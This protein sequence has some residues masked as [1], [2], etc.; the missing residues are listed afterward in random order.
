MVARI[1]WTPSI[2]DPTWIGWVTVVAYGI[3]VLLCVRAGMRARQL[4][5]KG[6][7]DS[8]EVWFVFAAVLFFLGI[9]KQLDL[10]TLLIQAGRE[11]ALA[12]SWYQFRRPVQL[13]FVMIL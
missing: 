10:Q 1:T 3:A 7:D 8:P 13:V 11:V 12:E 6:R 9:N 4:G 2:G 5:V